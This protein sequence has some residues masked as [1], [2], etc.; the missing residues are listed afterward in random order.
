[1]RQRQMP[2][3]PESAA[4]VIGERI[5]HMIGLLGMTQAVV[6]RHGQVADERVEAALSGF[7]A[8]TADQREAW[9][10]RLD[11]LGV[12]S[13]MGGR[14]ASAAQ[15]LTDRPGSAST[16]L[17]ELAAILAATAA[18]YIT[19]YTTARLLFDSA[20]CD[21]AADHL[22]A[23]DEGIHV[24][25]WLLPDV[26]GR[27]LQ[28]DR[29]LNCRCVCPSCS[30]G[31]CLCVRNST[32]TALHAWGVEPPYGTRGLPDA[33][34]LDARLDRWS[35][36]TLVPDRGVALR[37]PPRPDSPLATV[38]LS[39]GDRIVQVGDV[40]VNSNPQIQEAL[41]AYD[42]DDEIRLTVERTSGETTDFFVRRPTT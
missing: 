33:E 31:A 38:G 18:G 19:L 1:M 13:S 24:I 27:E 22:R 20:T 16:V 6:E 35:L 41:S 5:A 42:P 11:D 9:S 3:E 23:T 39:R 28:D 17:E 14:P 4:E 21:L 29:G 30:I 26:V 25:N 8:L 10:A 12:S 2:V 36:G 37:S 40:D 7:E 34:D 32:D 15:G